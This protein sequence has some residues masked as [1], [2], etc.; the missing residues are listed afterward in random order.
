MGFYTSKIDSSQNQ[1]LSTSLER[2]YKE[3]LNALFSFEIRHPELKLWSIKETSK[4]HELW[5]IKNWPLSESRSEHIVRKALQRPIEC[6][7]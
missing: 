6:T 3:L 7:I 2:P 5:Y 4:Q 1:D